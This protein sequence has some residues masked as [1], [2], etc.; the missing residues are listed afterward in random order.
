VQKYKIIHESHA[1]YLSDSEYRV[2]LSINMFQN[3]G[4]E[5]IS[6]DM[7]AKDCLMGEKTV[8]RSLAAMKERELIAWDRRL[9]KRDGQNQ[10]W[11]DYDINLELKLPYQGWSYK[12]R[13]VDTRCFEGAPAW[14]CWFVAACNSMDGFKD[15]PGKRKVATVADYLGLD[16]R[17][18]QK[19]K[20][21]LTVVRRKIYVMDNSLRPHE[22]MLFYK[23]D[24]VI[25]MTDICTI[26]ENKK[27]GKR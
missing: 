26:P 23:K 3:I 1:R 27:W 8:D 24:E 9:E 25:K 19:Y 15:H 13:L 4:K 17:T 16:R 18:V 7:I 6:V 20:D 11:N 12:A 2:L 21:I 22:T 5:L 10:W 14:A